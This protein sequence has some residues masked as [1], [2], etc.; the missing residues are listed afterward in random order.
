M[1]RHIII[2][3][4]LILVG[5]T[6]ACGKDDAP[7]SEKHT[8][9]ANVL[10]YDVNAPFASLHPSEIILS[11]SN[12]IFP[13]LYSYLVVP[14]GDGELKPDLADEWAYNRERLEWVIQLR[15]DARFH[16]GQTVTSDDVKHSLET[17]CQGTRPFL[18]SLISEI[19][20]PSER[21]IRIT[22]KKDGPDF[23]RKNWGMEIAPHPD[24]VA[25]DLVG[26]PI[27]SGPF[28]FVSRTGER[29]VTLEANE[30]YHQG[31]PPL[32]EVIFRFQPDKEKSWT[33]LL[34]GETDIAQEISP[35]NYEMIRQYGTN[36]YFDLY[37]LRY[38]TILLY[39]TSDPLFSDPSVRLALSHA[40]D[41]EYIIAEI[42]KGFGTVAPGP[43][44]VGSPYSDPDVKPIPYDPKMAADLLQAAGWSFDKDN[45]YLA[46][47]G[48]PF[49]FTIL[50][51]EESQIERKVA[52]YL[53]LCLNELG[54]KVRI[55]LLPYSEL[56][57]RYHRNSGFQAVLTELNAVGNSPEALRDMWCLD[58]PKKSVAGAFNDPEVTLVVRQALDEGDPHKQRELVHEVERLIIRRLLGA[59]LFHKTAI[60]ALSRRFYLPHPFSLTDRG[61]YRLQHARL[62][63]N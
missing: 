53:R 15:R 27:G 26:R 13:L 63:D 9:S 36:F 52:R 20:L 34:S 46:R 25:A 55:E 37:P 4:S 49:E 32:D 14:D 60:N 33:R 39:N 19:A 8:G 38:Y 11:G 56:K 62:L 30:D 29:K 1:H 16:N 48:R 2:L 44:G 28:R 21:T 58:S 10:R 47:G 45:R 51:F 3:L 31:R 22:L 7:S 35:K 61:I 40:I 57:L 18:Y 23:L 43:M 59:F 24:R 12:H 6:G 54:I 42:L 41:R 17:V 5:S 50:A